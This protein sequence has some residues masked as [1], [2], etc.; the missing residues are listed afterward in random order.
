MDAGEQQ[1]LLQWGMQKP[2]AGPP[3]PQQDHST[4]LELLCDTHWSGDTGQSLQQAQGLPPR[5]GSWFPLTPRSRR[6]CFV[7]SSAVTSFGDV[8][9][10]SPPVWEPDPGCSA[11]PVNSGQGMRA[12]PAAEGELPGHPCR[13]HPAPLQPW[14]GT[15]P[16][17]HP[18][19]GFRKC[20]PAATQVV[21]AMF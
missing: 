8:G 2:T 3:N 20:S 17:V 18:L 9:F 11:A 15:I 10:R 19:M 16:P 12:A 6:G 14:K 7:D 21:S 4:P 13:P 1:N 5:A